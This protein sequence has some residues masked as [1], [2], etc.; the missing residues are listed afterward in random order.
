MGERW[1]CGFRD[2]FGTKGRVREYLS[3]QMWL[4]APSAMLKPNPPPAHRRYSQ[5]AHAVTVCGLV[6]CVQYAKAA[7]GRTEE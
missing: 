5:N 2:Y 7:V 6:P 3:K 1:D 4:F